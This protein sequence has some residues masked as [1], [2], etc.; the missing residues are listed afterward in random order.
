MSFLPF[1]AIF[2]PFFPLPR[3]EI[4]KPS[5]DSENKER[6]S[7]SDGDEDHQDGQVPA[8]VA[9]TK[10]AHRTHV[11]DQAGILHAARLKGWNSTI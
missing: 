11:R 8:G 3:G 7:Q 9:L 10:V 1:L 6:G 2:W 5:N 4:W